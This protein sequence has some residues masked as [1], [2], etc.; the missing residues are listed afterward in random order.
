MQRAEHAQLRAA[1]RVGR[2][3]AAQAAAEAIVVLLVIGS[4][5]RNVSYV[6]WAFCVSSL[7]ALLYGIY[8]ER[9]SHLLGERLAQNVIGA[10]CVLVPAFLL[11]P[12]P[13]TTVV[14]GRAAGALA[15]LS[16]LLTAVADGAPR[17]RLATMADAAQRGIDEV[18]DAAR[19]LIVLARIGR[20]PWAARLARD[21]TECMDAARALLAGD[22]PP[23]PAKVGALRSRVGDLRRSLKR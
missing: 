15:A 4:V 1:E 20:E 3:L 6:F 21:A 17:D 12:I 8:G 9:G 19:P 5:L 11:F 10:A 18:R 22:A 7:L 23:D 13:T 2:A 14:R 16:E